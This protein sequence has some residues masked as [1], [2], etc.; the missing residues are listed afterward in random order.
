M[1]KKRVRD[2]DVSL[3]LTARLTEQVNAV[4]ATGE[5]LEQVTPVTAELLKFWFTE[6]FMQERCY[7]FHKGQRQAILN[8]IYLHEVLKIKDVVSIYN[9]VCPDLLAECDMAAL[10]ET[11]YALPKYAVKMATGTGKT[12][13]MHA[14]LIWQM[15]N[16]RH[17]EQPSG[18]YTTRFLL[19][20]PGLVVYDRLLDAFKGRLKPG[21]D[22]RDPENN[23]FYRWQELF[24]PP[25]Y[26]EEVFAF[27]R[28]NTVSKEDGIGLKTT[29]DGLIALTNWHLFL[30]G[31]DRQEGE[32]EKPSDVVDDL[33]PL[34]PGVTA[35]NSLETL[36]RQYLRGREM[37]YLASLPD[38]MVIN[39]EAH[40]IHE[41]TRDGMKEEVEWQK[42]L[43]TI[44]CGK[45]GRFYQVDFSATPYETSG[46]A[47]NLRKIYFPHIIVDFGLAEAMKSGLVK[48]LLLDR[49]QALTELQD[50]DYRAVRNGRNVVRLSEGQQLMLRAGLTKLRLLEDD[51]VKL[52]ERKHPKM[53]VICEDT[54]VTPFVEQFLRDEGLSAED[55][56][57]IDSSQ[58]GEMKEE[59]WKRVRE[60]LFNVDSYESPKVIISV[61]ML[62]E[63]FDVNNIC[64]IV[65][66]RSSEAPI[67]LE[68]VVGR[69]LRLMWREQDYAEEK[70]EN[71]NRVLVERLQPESMID[72][73]FV[74]EHPAF[75]DFY[76]DLMA[77]GAMG[78]DSGVLEESGGRVTGDLIR[79]G[80]KEGY[81]AYD[82][83]WPHVIR[84]AEKEITRS[85]IDV[86]ELEPFTAY[87]LDLLRKFLATPGETFI[88]KDIETDTTFGKYRVTADLFHAESYNEYLQKILHT[89]TTRI[90]RV[91]ERSYRPLPT[92]QINNPDILRI[93]DKFIRTRLFKESFDPFVDNNWKI[94]LAR[95][96][97][98]TQHLVRE[99]SLA[100]HKM[101][102]NVMSKDA[103]VE[104]IP[105]SS[106]KTLRMREAY[107]MK[108]RKTIYERLGYPSHSGELEREFM[109]FLDRDS[110][111]ERFLKIN[112]TQHLFASIYYIREDGLI[113][114]YHP[115]F[116]VATT[117]HVYLVET[118]GDDRL[119]DKNVRRKQQATV[120]WCRKINSLQPEYRMNRDWEY[121][122]LGES[123]FNSS[124]MGNATFTD[125]CRSYKIT[126][127]STRGLLF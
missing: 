111:V 89:V 91:G 122:L 78:E 61:L 108:I 67:L 49:R 92:L 42:G 73:L 65:P 19:V 5:M 26:R 8:I 16:A 20:A 98:V 55:V 12:W 126:E 37:E 28:N 127:A 4:M 100:I 81:Q 41:N 68:Q 10:G 18:R 60:K 109:E 118:K 58:K 71:R 84:D 115:D 35:G 11:K 43:D 33:L 94:L 125:L 14:L 6:P 34:R 38:L 3:R 114:S 97:V 107:S 51:F 88:S 80:L 52:D 74:I 113:A 29:G 30:T 27:I 47:K 2:N 77:Q 87:P 24:L 95:N 83:Y 93:I 70:L 82:F 85:Q 105:F 76:K 25:Q 17:E 103:A 110:E 32:G 72:M 23:D 31:N 39:D 46:S 53:L 117:H 102:E 50:L 75:R 99:M 69:G 101:Q 104:L 90:D 59:E 56:L 57:R 22:E 86:D 44:A 21:T 120:E 36:D 66:L 112:E 15:L 54:K 116:I 96:G 62:R 121:V 119:E 48:M 64:V 7:N 9:K 1:A 123:N 13:V 63:G 40:H 45:Q 106:V 79:V 124:Q